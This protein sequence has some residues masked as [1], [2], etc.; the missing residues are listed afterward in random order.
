MTEKTTKR[1]VID[2]GQRGIALV[3]A[4]LATSILLALGVAVVFSATTDQTTTKTHRSGQQAFFAADAGLGVA[5][6]A[7]AQAF[8]E[9]VDAVRAAGQ[10]AFA[11]NNPPA[12]TGAFP[13][14]Q[15]VPTPGDGTTKSTNF[16]NAIRTRA[17]ALANHTARAQRLDQLNGSKFAVQYSP[18]TGNIGLHAADAYAATEFAVLRYSIT[19]TGKTFIGGSATVHETG[20]LEIV[21][22]L[23]A[24]GGP[25][26]R[27]FR[28]SGF[29]AFFDNGDTQANAPLASGTFS[30]PV[31]TNTHFAYLSSR[32]VTFR[33]VV[34]QVD[35]G[36]RYDNLNNTTPNIT[37][38][39]TANMTGFTLS[40]E[41]YRKI[42]PV[43]LPTNNFS[44]EF[45]VINSTGVMDRHADGSQ[46]DPPSVIPNDSS[47]HPLPVLDSAGRV[48]AAVLAANLRNISN[49]APTLSGGALP[50]GVYI[51]SANGTSITGAGIYV[52]GDVSDL[53]LKAETNGDQVYT[54]V[55][56]TT[57]TTVRTNYTNSTTTVSSGSTTRTYTGVFTDRADPNNVQPGVSLFVNGSIASLRGGKTSTTSNAAIAAQTRLT[58][59]AQRN[60]TV[61][62][63]LKYANP[64]AN[65]DGTPVT[66]LS[67]I[68]N[69]LGIFTNDGNC[70]LAP[71]ASYVSGP[72]L[73]LEM[74]AAVVTFNNNTSN[75]GGGIDGSIVYTGGTAS[76]TNDRWRLVGSRVQSKINSIGYTYR[77]IYFDVR[78]SGGR[79][80]PPFFP[81]TT[82]SLG[83]PP[84]A[85]SVTITSV[86]APAP[87]AMSW[88]R[89]NN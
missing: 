48:T 75:D 19:V 63:D 9:Q 70:G 46:V 20:R 77:D 68:K 38:L 24:H 32:S 59:T 65:S 27:S 29:A 8:A 56:G 67:D 14:I 1:I 66:N 72:G 53:Q 6:S 89:D 61:T 15:V 12:T 25:S 17:L 16:Y 47:G 40:A 88:F 86:N 44:Q 31:H 52:Q 41:G 80:A 4:L 22:S 45:A 10:T 2:E 23:E 43:P 50:T 49:V 21:T 55:Q 28:F 11:R 83:P 37:P 76:G 57:T 18:L 34:S 39:P 42:D 71:N 87:T 26:T 74:N 84:V 3:T 58:V 33:N 54:F 36:I 5:R 78:F 7:L 64:V 62:G 51:S 30:G 69:V 79:F 85:S 60:I 81:G 35:N 13:D 82:Y 73:S